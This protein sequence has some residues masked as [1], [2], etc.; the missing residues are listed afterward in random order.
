MSII[1]LIPAPLRM[2]VVLGLLAV[3]VAGT[4]GATWWAIS[5]RI[6]LQSTRADRA[7]LDLGEQREL[8]A[9]QARVLEAQ[10]ADFERLGRVELQMQQLSQAIQRNTSAHNR[11][12]EEL[13]RNDKAIVDYLAQPVPAGLGLLYARPETTDP[14]AYTAPP[15]VQPAV[16]PGAVP[17]ASTPAAVDQ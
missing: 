13:K 9:L 5:P 17:A 1:D 4:A 11:A 16:Q 7:E 14:A 8:T 2:W 3:L 12:L 6:E 10:Q 15:A